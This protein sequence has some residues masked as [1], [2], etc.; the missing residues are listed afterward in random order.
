MLTRCPDCSAEV[1]DAAPAC[2]KCGRPSGRAAIVQT[3]AGAT[4]KFLDPSANVR[5]CLGVIALLVVLVVGVL[6]AAAM[7]V[8]VR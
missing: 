3:T 6:V 2:P 8:S 4:G 1:S 5:S 7:G